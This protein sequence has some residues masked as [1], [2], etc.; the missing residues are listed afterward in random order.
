LDRPLPVGQFATVQ[1]TGTQ[2]YDLRG[3]PFDE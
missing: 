3:T 2:V 1:V